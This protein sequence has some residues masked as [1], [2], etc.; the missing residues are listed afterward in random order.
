MSENKKWRTKILSNSFVPKLYFNE[1]FI[2]SY[3]FHIPQY[4]TPQTTL[5]Y[6]TVWM[7][8]TGPKSCDEKFNILFIKMETPQPNLHSLCCC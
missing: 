1:I 3:S 2:S 5:H 8:L 7:I 4:K 6:I